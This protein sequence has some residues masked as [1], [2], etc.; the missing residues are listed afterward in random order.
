MSSYTE[1]VDRL[2]W[3]K[4]VCLGGCGVTSRS[5]RTGFIFL[6]VVHWAERRVTRRGLRRFLLLLA[7]RNREAD[8][9][10][11]NA[12]HLTW[13]HLWAD[14]QY[15]NALAGIVGFRFPIEFSRTERAK[16]LW[17]AHKNKVP[18]TRTHPAIYAWVSRG[19]R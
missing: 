17:L 14:E 15:A 8:P 7:R 12:P 5:H 11:L 4:R 9:T 10:Y 2:G 3:P 1:I 19:L 18:I 16:C 13:Y 6:D